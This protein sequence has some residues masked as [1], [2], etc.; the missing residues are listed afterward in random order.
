MKVEACK[1]T[2][3]TYIDFEPLKQRQLSGVIEHVKMNKID[4]STNEEVGLLCF[5]IH[6]KDAISGKHEISGAE[7]VSMI[8]QNMT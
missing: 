3:N 5:I 7:N 8:L 2:N 1:A 4:H 6:A